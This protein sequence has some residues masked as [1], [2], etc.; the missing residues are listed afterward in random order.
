MVGNN[1]TGL[2]KLDR[3]C[4]RL[5]GSSS[6]SSSSGEDRSRK[7]LLYHEARFI[8]GYIRLFVHLNQI[9]LDCWSGRE[10]RQTKGMK[11]C[12]SPQKSF[13]A[14]TAAIASTSALTYQC[15]CRRCCYYRNYKP[16]KARVRVR[17]HYPTAQQIPT[18][19]LDL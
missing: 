11:R 2:D 8:D 1:T 10:K 5:G 16:L 18:G 14:T 17:A 13:S 15:R 3:R 6:S 12:W 19:T 7:S 4:W 9:G